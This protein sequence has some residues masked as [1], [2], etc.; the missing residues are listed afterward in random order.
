MIETHS[1]TC[2]LELNDYRERSADV[3]DQSSLVLSQRT[4]LIIVILGSVIIL[5][6]LLGKNTEILLL[7]LNSVTHRSF[8]DDHNDD[9]Y[10]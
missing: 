6:V 10:N 5:M 3:C 2:L 9:N 1:G 7:T 4:E 8:D